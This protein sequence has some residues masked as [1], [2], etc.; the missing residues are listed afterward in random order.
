MLEHFHSDGISGFVI[1][2]A[3]AFNSFDYNPKYAYNYYDALGH[4]LFS[5]LLAPYLCYSISFNPE[6]EPKN[7]Q[8]TSSINK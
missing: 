1:I 6:R 7:F 4:F 3:S 8:L 2:F 5:N